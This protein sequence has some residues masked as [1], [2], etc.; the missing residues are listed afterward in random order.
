[1][2]SIL[3]SCIMLCFHLCILN[4]NLITKKNKFGYPIYILADIV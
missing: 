4:K 3:R 1:M 2:F